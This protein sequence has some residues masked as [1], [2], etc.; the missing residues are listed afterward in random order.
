MDA[1]VSLLAGAK[2]P[3]M[4]CGRGARSDHAWHARIRLAERL[5]A[6]VMT[7]LKSG[8]QF[9][10]DHSAHI[11]PPFNALSTLA[12]EIVRDFKRGRIA[13]RK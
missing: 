8:A 9:P 4:L 11:V 5:G 7:D 3:L 6:L 13:T 10:T 12:R 2:R 1:A